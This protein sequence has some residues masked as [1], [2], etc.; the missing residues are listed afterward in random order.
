MA[1]VVS[2]MALDLAIEAPWFSQL[3]T[4]IVVLS[5]AADQA[6]LVGWSSRIK[7]EAATIQEDF[8]CF[9]LQIPWATHRGI[10]RPT[11]DGIR[12]L[13]AKAARISTVT[14]GLTDWYGLDGIP[15]EPMQGRMHC[16]RT[17]CRWDE[18]LRK[19]WILSMSTAL[20]LALVSSVVLAAFMG[21]LVMKMVL[22]AAA[23]LRA[24]TWLAVESREQ[25]AAKKRANRIHRYLSSE[26]QDGPI[27]MCDVRLAQDAIFEHRRSCPT[28]PDWFYRLRKRAHEELEHG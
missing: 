13:A 10:E 11:E 22:L 2:I 1:I 15:V 26:G 18:R 27:S 6:L 20:T 19:E 28:V 3:T 25:S 14:E 5:W 4:L 9:V 21:V 7:E 16:Q 24:L 17:N 8:D 23:S 12:E